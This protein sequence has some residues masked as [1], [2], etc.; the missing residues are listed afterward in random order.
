MAFIK[1]E[2]PKILYTISEDVHSLLKDL[3]KHDFNK[4]MHTKYE[5][6]FVD[7][8]S[9]M[10]IYFFFFLRK[11]HYEL[12]IDFLSKNQTAMRVVS[13]MMMSWE[14]GIRYGHIETNKDLIGTYSN[15]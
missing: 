11:H 2:N 6:L 4:E 8:L 9:R 3:A 7:N 1:L 12:F 15:N 14:A 13:V 10:I 5:H